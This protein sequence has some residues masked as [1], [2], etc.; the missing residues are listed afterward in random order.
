MEKLLD[1]YIDSGQLGNAVLPTPEYCAA[2]LHLSVPYFNDL[3]KFETGKTLDEYFQLKRLEAAKKMLLKAENTP[4][5]VAQ[6]LGY[7]NVQYFSLLF[8]KITGIAPNE[9]RCS[10]N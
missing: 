3:L 2:H 10:Q 7:P 4:A 9:Y 8:K 6:L 1:G 5:V